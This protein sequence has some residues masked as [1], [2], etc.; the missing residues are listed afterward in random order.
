MNGQ[1]YHMRPWDEVLGPDH[2]VEETEG[3]CL[4]LVGKIPVMLPQELASKIRELKGQRI[5]ILRTD[6]DYRVRILS[7]PKDISIAEDA[8]KGIA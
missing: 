1:P 5:G 8:I 6:C 4:A 2:E 7:A 3:Y